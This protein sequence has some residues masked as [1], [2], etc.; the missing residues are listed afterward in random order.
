MYIHPHIAMMV[1]GKQIVIPKD[2]GISPLLWKEHT[3]DKF[4]MQAMPEMGMSGM[5]PLHTHDDSGIIHVE[6][7][8]NRNYTL[9]EFLN[10]W[11]GLNFENKLVN[12]TIDGKPITDYN[13]V[14]LE[15]IRR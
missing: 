7:T 13:N 1:D 10:I 12:A 5:A 15:I 8:K 4:G 2:I 14:I 9:G 6:S 11:G 3:L